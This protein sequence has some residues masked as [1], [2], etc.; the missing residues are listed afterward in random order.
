[1]KKHKQYTAVVKIGDGSNE[2]GLFHV[3]LDLEASS[4]KRAREKALKTAL[5]GTHVTV[6][7]SEGR[8]VGVN[9]V[10]QESFGA[11]PEAW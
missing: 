4:P 7:L 2:V 3:R 6:E 8:D 9:G 5:S 11:K 1:M 10:Y